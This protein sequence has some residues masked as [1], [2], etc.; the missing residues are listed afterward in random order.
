MMF[1][2]YVV[3][4]EHPRDQLGRARMRLA[5]DSLS[6]LESAVRVGRTACLDLLEGSGAL[7]VARAHVVSPPAY[8]NT[9]QLIKLA[10]RLGA[11][12]Y[13]MTKFWIQN[14]VDGS[15]TEHNPTVS[16]LAELHRERRSATAGVS[17][18][19][20]RLSAIAH[21]KSSSLPALK[22]ALQFFAGLH[23]S[24]WLHPPIPFEVRDGLGITWRHSI[25]RRT[26]SVT[27]EAGRYS[28]VISGGRVLF[29]RT[30]K[31]STTT[32]SF[33]GELGV[34]TSH[35]VIEYFHSGQF[36]AE[37]DATLPATGAA[38]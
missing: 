35:L 19:L 30:R 22:L 25:L 8:P 26:D 20:A 6:E 27:R 28:V 9:N 15:L 21:G 37:R 36:P 3:D 33:E 5:A 1:D 32:E 38:A 2:V 12:F 24:D 29:L 18:A 17:G 31:I 7:D 14:Q 11:P 34:D 13:D 23:D 4:L 10:T 16:E